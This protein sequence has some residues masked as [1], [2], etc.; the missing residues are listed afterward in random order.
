LAYELLTNGKDA[1]AAG[2]IG[3]PIC[4]ALLHVAAHVTGRG[5]HSAG[6]A[7]GQ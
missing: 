6:A 1:F 7:R 4:V 5:Q 3:L 2:L